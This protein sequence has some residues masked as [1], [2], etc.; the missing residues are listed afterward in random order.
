MFLLVAWGQRK[1]KRRTPRV[2]SPTVLTI[3]KDGERHSIEA[4]AISLFDAAY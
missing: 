1:E 2:R 4:E 3:G